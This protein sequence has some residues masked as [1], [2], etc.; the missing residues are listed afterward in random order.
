MWEVVMDVAMGQDTQTSLTWLVELCGSDIEGLQTNAAEVI[1]FFHN[2]LKVKNQV[3]ADETDQDME[4]GTT[5]TSQNL[6]GN[7][8]SHLDHPG[9][10]VLPLPTNQSIISPAPDPTGMSGDLG[11]LTPLRESE[12]GDPP[13]TPPVRTSGC[14]TKAP[15]ALT[16]GESLTRAVPAPSKKR[17]LDDGAADRSKCV[18]QLAPKP[19]DKVAHFWE[20][21]ST[22]VKNM[23]SP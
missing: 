2:G 10:H 14:K 8:P 4:T 19:E 20:F 3:A 13:V 6:D 5:S 7:A 15:Q 21:Q 22:F 16:A 23:V 12:A 17:K 11:T 9:D 18:P 1:T